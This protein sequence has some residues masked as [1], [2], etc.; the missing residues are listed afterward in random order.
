MQ[1]SGTR[2]VFQ[3]IWNF[4]WSIFHEID[5]KIDLSKTYQKLTEVEIQGLV[6]TAVTCCVLDAGR[7]VTS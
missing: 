1:V 2:H 3:G 7:L 4:F 5:N 6:L